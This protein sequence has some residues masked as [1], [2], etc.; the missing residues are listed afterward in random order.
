MDRLKRRVICL[1]AEKIGLSLAEGKEFL[2][3]LQRLMLQTQSIHPA[4]DVLPE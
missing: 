2:A 4:S 1:T 3:E